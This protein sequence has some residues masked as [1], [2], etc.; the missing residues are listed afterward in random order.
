MCSVSVVR[1][2]LW[3]SLRIW[4]RHRSAHVERG[5]ATYIRIYEIV[6]HEALVCVCVCVCMC[7]CVC[8]SVC[9]MRC[10][11]YW[12]LLAVCVCVCVYVCVFIGVCVCVRARACVCHIHHLTFCLHKA[13]LCDSSSRG[14]VLF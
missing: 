12:L 4:H 8:V 1:F 14:I 13:E 3:T 5:A 7:T 6:T 2:S 10:I 9:E 11:Q